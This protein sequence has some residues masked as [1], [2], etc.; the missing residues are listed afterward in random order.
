MLH[1]RGVPRYKPTSHNEMKSSELMLMCE[2]L[3]RVASV[4]FIAEEVASTRVGLPNPTPVPSTS[5]LI[6]RHKESKQQGSTS[7]NVLVNQ[8]LYSSY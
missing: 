1:R 5:V 7:T 2:V 6:Q 8:K 3:L 4:F